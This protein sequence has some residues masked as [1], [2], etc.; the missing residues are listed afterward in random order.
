MY[1]ALII[2]NEF[3]PM[4]GAGVQR[5]TKFVKYLREF[6]IEP[7][8]VTKD[9]KGGLIDRTLLS[10]IPDGVKIYRLKAYDTV[11][12]GGIVRLPMKFLGTR[13]MSPDSEY[14]WYLFNRDRKSVV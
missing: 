10:D 5:T 8:V 2:A 11:N 13:I 9:Q 14:F 7:V 4:G 1:K 12:K 3:P 6:G